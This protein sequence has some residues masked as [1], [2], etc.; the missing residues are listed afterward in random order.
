MEELMSGRNNFKKNEVFIKFIVYLCKRMPIFLSHQFLSR[1]S[2]ASGRLGILAR[3]IY[4]AC[5][6]KKLGDSAYFGEYCVIKNPEMLVIGDNFSLHEFSYVDA[7]GGIVVG[8]NVSIAH[9]S[10]ILSANHQWN[11]SSKPIKYNEIQMKPVLIEDDVW[12]GCG[13]RILAGA[14]IGSRVVVAAGAVVSG[15]LESGYVYA[16]VPA[17]KIKKL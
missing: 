7:I 8:S 1:L 5:F 10:S 4:G 17:K 16:G 14:H 9:S 2:R 13:V 3:Y 6:F 15:S 11:D 12:I